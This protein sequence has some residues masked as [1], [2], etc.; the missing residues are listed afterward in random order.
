VQQNIAV[1]TTARSEF[2]QLKPVLDALTRSEA[3]TCQLF[4]SGSHLAASHGQTERDITKSGLR[5]AERL[6]ILV[7]DDSGV[8]AALTAGL[9]VQALGGALERN[10]TDVLLLAGDRYETL[11]AAVAATCVGVPIAHLHG[12]E[13]TEGALDD[14]CRHAITKLSSLHFVAT[15]VYRER[16]V[17]MGEQPERVFEVGAPFLDQILATELFDLDQMAERL[18]LDIEPPVAVVA[19][20]PV[21]RA[22]GDDAAICHALLRALAERCA[23]IILTAPNSDPGRDAIVN[24][25]DDFQRGNG[26]ARL[27]ENLGS[28]QF[29]S[30]MALADVMVGN[31]S[32]GIHEAVSFSLPVVN[33]GSRQAGRLCPRNVIHCA[34]D[35]DAI[36]TA[37]SQALTED[38]R[39]GV[40]GIDNPYGDGRASERIVALLEQFAPSGRILLQKKFADGNSV[41]ETAAAWA[42][43]N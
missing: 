42:H 17:Q 25:M 3:L 11:A 35:Y 16:V 14:A 20:H 28:Q 21:T 30:L 26:H 5:I 23:T 27:Y 39:K 13:V 2:Y 12:G 19:Y 36:S 15:D 4:V 9:A 22:E 10:R 33:V 1:L 40:L 43:I 8:G 29:L 31:S 37:V 34:E 24:V 38:F 41:A 6:P 32:S 7:E 18:S